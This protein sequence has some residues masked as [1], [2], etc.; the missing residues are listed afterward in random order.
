MTAKK[1]KEIAPYDP[2]FKYS[3]I[4]EEPKT[5]TIL[6]KKLPDNMILITGFEN[7]L[8]ADELTKKYGEDIADTYFAYDYHMAKEYYADGTILLSVD[9]NDEDCDTVRPG[10]VYQKHEFHKLVEHIR[11]CGGLLH[12]IIAAVNNGETKMITI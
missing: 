5:A 3:S 12:D 8:T 11:K 1:I 7:F 9:F 2:K 4:K 10:N 6:Y